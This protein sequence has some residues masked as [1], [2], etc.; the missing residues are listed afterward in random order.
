MKIYASHEV[1]VMVMEYFLPC[2]FKSLNVSL[3]LWLH[4]FKFFPWCWYHAMLLLKI[5]TYGMLV[6]EGKEFYV[7]LVMIYVFES[8]YV[9]KM[10]E[11]VKT[12]CKSLTCE[13]KK[14]RTMRSNRRE[15]W[16]SWNLPPWL[17][18][19]LWVFVLLL[20]NEVFKSSL[21]VMLS[22]GNLA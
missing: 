8:C 3:F 1:M 11:Q 18:T 9:K 17:S 10:E 14:K 7:D 5:K 12:M 20:K 22:M 2:L 6:W 15:S 13:W 21:F 19:S 4:I 16:G